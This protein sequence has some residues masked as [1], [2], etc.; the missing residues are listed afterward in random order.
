MICVVAHAGDGNTHPVIVFDPHDPDAADRATWRSLRRIM[1]SSRSRS[2]APSPVS[3]AW[4]GS[5]DWLPDQ[6]G[7]DVMVLTRRIKDAAR[8]ARHPQS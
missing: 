5:R 7:D 2:A 8:P 1:E 4:A 6:L 3:T